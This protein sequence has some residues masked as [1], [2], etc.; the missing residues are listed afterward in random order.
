MYRLCRSGVVAHKLLGRISGGM[1]PSELFC[2]VNAK[3][4]L[5]GTFTFLDNVAGHYIIN[6]QVSNIFRYNS[7]MSTVWVR[8]LICGQLFECYSLQNATNLTLNPLPNR[9]NITESGAI[10]I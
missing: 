6:R 8:Y 10:A 1:L 7:T 4:P 3:I 2:P 9:V 5:F